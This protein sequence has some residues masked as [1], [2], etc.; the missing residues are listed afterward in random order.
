MNVLVVEDDVSTAFSLKSSIEGWNH[1]V[2]TLETWGEALK[3]AKVKKFDLAL[4]DIFLPDGRGHRLIPQL[5][6]LNHNI[7]II[8]MTGYNSRNLEQEVRQQ[9]ISYYLIKPF[10]LEIL[11]DILDH[12]E[13]WKRKEGNGI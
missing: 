7:G 12:L 2:E 3:M 1:D 11:K 10:D 6:S 13:K 4:L 8:T 9:G 5:R